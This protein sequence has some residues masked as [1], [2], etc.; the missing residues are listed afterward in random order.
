MTAP[1]TTRT[2]RLWHGLADV[3]ADLGPRVVTLGVFDGV[4]RGHARLIGQALATGREL[5]VPTVLV[6][7]DPHPARVVG[8]PRDTAVLSSIERRAELAWEHGVAEVC[9]LPFT[10]A[11]A[12]VG[13]AEFV[14]EVLVE[15][16]R[17]AAVVVG[18][19][20]TF[21]HRGAG[22]L[23]TLRRLGGR[24]GFRVLGVDLLRGADGATPCS[25][26]YIRDC[27]RRGDLDAA[28]RALGRPHHLEG[29]LAANGELVV[30]KDT[31]LPRPGRY[32]GRLGSGGTGETVDVEVTV[33]GR[34]VLRLPR[35]GPGP[36]GLDLLAAR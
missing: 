20:F 12:R 36:A 26:T 5:G 1:T 32:A 17:A 30:P 3:P 2:R 35:R 29:Y 10:K 8:L 7:F 25:S 21:G 18:E 27:L 34:V 6:T 22:T 15:R 4:H 23:G 31:A 16:L 24:H 14:A 28:A 13:P 9:V 19:N 33:E 11:F